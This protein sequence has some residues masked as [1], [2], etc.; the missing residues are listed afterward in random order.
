MVQ[1]AL[2]PT[3]DHTADAPHMIQ[4]PWRPVGHFETLKPAL[5]KCEC[6]RSDGLETTM[7]MAD[8]ITVVARPISAG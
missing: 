4:N 6:L 5:D 8:C 3:A 1:A 2:S 7:L